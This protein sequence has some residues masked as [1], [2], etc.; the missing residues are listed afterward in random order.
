MLVSLLENIANLNNLNIKVL[1]IFSS[2]ET[3]HQ[4]FRARLLVKLNTEGSRIVRAKVRETQRGQWCL[5]A[6]GL[7]SMTT[8]SNPRATTPRISRIST[9]VILKLL[10]GTIS[11]PVVIQS[12]ITNYSVRNFKIQVFWRLANYSVGVSNHSLKPTP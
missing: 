3:F 4:A 1:Y 5:Y 7:A 9:L 2:I 11:P 12:Q 8:K 10:L 6:S